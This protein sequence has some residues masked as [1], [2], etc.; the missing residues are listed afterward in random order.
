MN[1]KF[2]YKTLVYC[3]SCFHTLSG[4]K[5][6][7]FNGKC[8]NES[9]KINSELILFNIH[10]EIR[11]VVSMNYQVLK[12]YQDNKDEGPCSDILFGL[13]IFSLGRR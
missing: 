1:V 9:S 8:R 5:E 10:D 12:W 6:K 13:R 4:I 11:R 2:S 7:C 3:S